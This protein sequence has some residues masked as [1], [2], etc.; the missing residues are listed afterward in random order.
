MPNWTYNT[1]TVKGEKKDLDKMM[2]DAVR[3]EDGKLHFS[4]WFPIPETFA[5]YDTANHPD[6][7][8][9]K[10]G[11]AWDDGLGSHESVVTE[12]LI[13]EFKRAT[14]EQ[15]EKYGV[16][17][18]FDYNVMM[19]GVKWDCELI[20]TEEDDT[21]I[22]IHTETPWNAPDKFLLR[23]SRKYPEL[24]FHGY[25]ISEDDFWEENEYRGGNK[26]ELGS[27]EYN[28]DED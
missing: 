3:A 10:V 27:G 4:G 23:M 19:F 15:M 28:W 16:V 5:K 13:E 6:G 8:G 14:K 20:I 11:D 18:W 21:R 2:A 25:A 26:T 24:T 7:E 22:I 12:Q 17:G 1:I 9:L